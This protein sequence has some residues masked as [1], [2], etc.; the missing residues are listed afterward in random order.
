[1]VSPFKSKVFFLKLSVFTALSGM[2]I[3]AYMSQYA[4]K[5]TIDFQKTVLSGSTQS[6]Q[7][8]PKQ[9]TPAIKVA[10][11][12]LNAAA[13]TDQ[14]INEKVKVEKSLETS[15][16]VEIKLTKTTKP[17][18]AKTISGKVLN[19]KTVETVEA[20]RTAKKQTKA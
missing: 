13:F 8:N 10:A 5:K 3:A 7:E 15:K 4:P 14:V 9:K 20:V 12:K 2:V 6:K 19:E 17:K 11:K 16:T 1:M 18:L